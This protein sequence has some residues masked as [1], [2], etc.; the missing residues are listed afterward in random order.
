MKL[1][2]NA[3][4]LNTLHRRRRRLIKR[5]RLT[6]LT[7]RDALTLAR[8]EARI[9]RLEVAEDRARLAKTPRRAP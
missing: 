3:S 2:G 4:I 1:S 9:D 6:E 8:L 5:K 7:P